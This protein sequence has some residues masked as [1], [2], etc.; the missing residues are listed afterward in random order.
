MGSYRIPDII[1]YFDDFPANVRSPRAVR[2]RT[3]LMEDK[4]A[5]DSH[6]SAGGSKCASVPLCSHKGN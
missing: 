6:C 5:S 3:D 4:S 1:Y 2:K